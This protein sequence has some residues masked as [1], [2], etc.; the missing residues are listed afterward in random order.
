MRLVPIDFSDLARID[1][2]PLDRFRHGLG[3][4]AVR[5]GRGIPS[6]R[7]LILDQFNVP[8]AKVVPEEVIEGLHRFVKLVSVDRNV[9]ITRGLV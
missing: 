5:I 8:V 6:G 4:F 3:L 1:I 9:E 2:G 7:D